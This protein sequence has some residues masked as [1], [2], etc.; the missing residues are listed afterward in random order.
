M[1]ASFKTMNDIDKPTVEVQFS[2]DKST[3]SVVVT[4]P[5]AEQAF[6]FRDVVNAL[7]NHM[8]QVTATPDLR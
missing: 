3:A 6:E 4:F 8:P 5:F 2:P 7:L 1:D